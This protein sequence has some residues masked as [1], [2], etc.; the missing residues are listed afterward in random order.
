ML[1]G[2]LRLKEEICESFEWNVTVELVIQYF[3]KFEH[4]RTAFGLLV[5]LVRL[6]PS[7]GRVNHLAKGQNA[8]WLRIR[9]EL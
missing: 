5:L 1:N 8:L 3:T 6:A 7:G 2:E 9:C 4:L